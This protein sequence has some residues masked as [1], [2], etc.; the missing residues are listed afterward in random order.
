MKG[1]IL[2]DQKDPRSPK[3]LVIGMDTDVS[4][5]SGKGAGGPRGGQ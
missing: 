1:K 2:S 4:D 3:Q 5:P